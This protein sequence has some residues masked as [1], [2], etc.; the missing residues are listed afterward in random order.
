MPNESSE[1]SNTPRNYTGVTTYTAGIMQASA[2]RLLQKYC[3]AVL[4]K[5]GITK[6]QWLVIGT[7]FDSGP[8]GIR[9]TELAAKLDT[10][11]AYITT[12]INLLE[13]KDILVRQAHENDTRAKMITIHPDFAPK[14]DD[15][16][17]TLRESLRKYVYKNVSPEDFQI[18]MKV[19]S[20]LS[21]NV[22]R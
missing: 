15:I 8:K 14:C 2:H 4:S 20:Q 18:Y 5:Y 9:M 16:E 17:A 11:Q 21:N 1:N 6:N 13:S 19:L 3:D 10:T 7:V 22:D 12:T